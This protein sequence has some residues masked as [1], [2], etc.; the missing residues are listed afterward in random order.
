M[1]SIRSWR[2]S[3]IMK[4]SLLQPEQQEQEEQEKQAEQE[5]QEEQQAQ[6]EEQV[7]QADQQE[8]GAGVAPGAGK[9]AV[10]LL[11]S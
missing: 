2:S 5:E 7:E 1:I 11:S 9:I 4:S 6:Q 8:Q 10:I 3:W